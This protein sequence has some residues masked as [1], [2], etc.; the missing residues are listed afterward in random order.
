MLRAFLFECARSG[1][2]S[3]MRSSRDLIVELNSE[4]EQ[5][6]AVAIAVGFPQHTEFV[7]SGDEGSVTRLDELVRDG[8]DPVGLL[9]IVISEALLQVD[10]RP[11]TEYADETWV[12]DY[13]QSIAHSLRNLLAGKG[14]G[15]LLGTGREFRARGQ[16]A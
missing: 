5:F 7:F 10:A 12:E 13:L 9:R 3:S 15:E 11:F 16:S 4:A 1:G 8:G 6:T 2:A 14:A